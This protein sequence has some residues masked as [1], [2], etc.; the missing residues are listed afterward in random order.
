MLNTLQLMRL[1][2]TPTCAAECK[3]SSKTN[4]KL[5]DAS[6]P[7]PCEQLQQDLVDAVVMTLPVVAQFET[8]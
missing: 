8:L 3:G 5:A 6:K 4:I 2:P 7:W 1:L